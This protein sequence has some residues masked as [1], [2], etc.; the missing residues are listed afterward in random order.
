MSDDHNRLSARMSDET[1]KEVKDLIGQIEDK[2]S[3]LITLTEDERHQIPVMSRSTELFVADTLQTAHQCR[4]AL[5][6]YV[7]VDELLKDVDLYDSL[8]RVLLPL[9]RLRDK[10]KDTKKLAG[11]EAYSSSSILYNMLQMAARMGVE[12]MDKAVLMLTQR[13][14]EYKQE[15]NS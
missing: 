2:M 15:E 12:D 3:F 1:I 7:D 6:A 13:Y 9:N 11:A 10:I 8:T 4:E 5:P 14:N